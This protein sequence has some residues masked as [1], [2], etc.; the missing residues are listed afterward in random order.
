MHKTSEPNPL[1][2]IR[3][4]IHHS[5]A[6]FLP[7]MQVLINKF[8]KLHEQ[9]EHLYIMCC[10]IE[11]ITTRAIKIIVVFYICKIQTQL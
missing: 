10:T 3:K 4:C 2:H 8:D 1:K 9:N 11:M 5:Q 7:W 6:S